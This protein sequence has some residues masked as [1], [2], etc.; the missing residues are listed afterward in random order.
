LVMAGRGEASR[1]S[2]APLGET[3]ITA[4]PGGEGCGKPAWMTA[5]R[6]VDYTARRCKQVFRERRNV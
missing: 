3:P 2:Y 6:P 5:L 1:A 4:W